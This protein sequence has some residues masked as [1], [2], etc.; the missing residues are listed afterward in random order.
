MARHRQKHIS[1]LPAYLLAP[2]LVVVVISAKVISWTFG[3]K[4]TEDLTARDVAS[5]LEDF[6]GGR[7]RKW[8][9]DDFCCIP[10][11]DPA[12]EAI[13]REAAFVRLPLDEAGEAKL[14]ALLART[15]SLADA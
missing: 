6:I 9:W 8:D 10:I 7:G 13:R 1:G 12:L 3:L 15:R 11:T 5:Y 14:R 4:Q 2:M